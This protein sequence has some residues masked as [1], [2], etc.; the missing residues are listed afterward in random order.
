[1]APAITGGS[2]ASSGAS[3]TVSGS[4]T[5]PGTSVG[6]T[7]PTTGSHGARAA[8]GTPFIVP[9][10]TRAGPSDGWGG[11]YASIARGSVSSPRRAIGATGLLRGRLPVSRSTG[12]TTSSTLFAVSP[13]GRATFTRVPADSAG[14]SATSSTMVPDARAGAL[15]TA[16]CAWPSTR[17]CVARMTGRRSRSI[18]A[19]LSSSTMSVPRSGRRLSAS[20][21]RPPSVTSTATDACSG[22][23]TMASGSIAVGIALPSTRRSLQWRSTPRQRE[24]SVWI[25]WSTG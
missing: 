12:P 23:I 1:M 9:C 19:S 6:T 20:R 18:V 4:S 3:G 8:G 13:G 11:G 10:V 15:C 24:R 17:P 16:R 22:G 5:M 21:R 2:A 14:S 7:S 25:G